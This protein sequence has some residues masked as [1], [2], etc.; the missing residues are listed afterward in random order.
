MDDN[1]CEDLLDARDLLYDW[2]IDH[3]EA[4]GAVSRKAILKALISIKKMIEEIE[5]EEG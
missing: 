1:E 5:E 4:K 2:I 3:P